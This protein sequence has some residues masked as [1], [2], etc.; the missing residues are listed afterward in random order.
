MKSANAAGAEK[1]PVGVEIGRAE[2]A[3]APP[4][5]V[6][7]YVRSAWRSWTIERISCAFHSLR[8]M[9]PI[10][11]I[12]AW[13]NG[14]QRPER[15]G[16]RVA[17]L[18]SMTRCTWGLPPSMDGDNPGAWAATSTVARAFGKKRAP[19][20]GLP[21]PVRTEALHLSMEAEPP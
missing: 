20:S 4:A 7:S 2:C 19:E 10:S 16:A 21:A 14:G 5:A 11:L 8:V 13:A 18:S 17:E 15:H 6:A 3:R 9:V 1:G 12:D